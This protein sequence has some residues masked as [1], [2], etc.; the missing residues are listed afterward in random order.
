MD[1]FK[2]INDTLGHELG[3]RLLKQV[4][5]RLQSFIRPSDTIARLGGDEFVLVLPNLSHIG[6]AAAVT[7]RMLQSIAEPFE[8]DSHELH[9]SASA[10]IATTELYDEDPLQLIRQADMAMFEAKRRG[11]S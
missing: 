10:G 8:L 11:R 1:G 6:D 2:P 4:V 5:E 3:D 7:E 9:I